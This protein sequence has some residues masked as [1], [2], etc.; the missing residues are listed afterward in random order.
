MKLF[1]SSPDK[2]SFYKKIWKQRMPDYMQYFDMYNYFD[3]FPLDGG[4]FYIFNHSH[5]IEN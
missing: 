4:G 2:I 5:P 3:I 1:E